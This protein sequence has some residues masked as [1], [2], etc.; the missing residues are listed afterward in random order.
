MNRINRVLLIESDDEMLQSHGTQLSKADFK[1]EEVSNAHDALQRARSGE[2]DLFIADVKMPQMNGLDLLRQIRQYSI[3][4][5]A[6]LLLDRPDN[7]IIVESTR[8]GVLQC[9]VKPVKPELLVK[10][11]VSLAKTSEG[12][13]ITN[14][15]G[16]TSVRP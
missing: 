7:E 3:K 2:F 4:T 10:A 11:T 8:L 13:L 9:L 16:V 6:L 14:G 15:S 1:V 5:Q 12:G